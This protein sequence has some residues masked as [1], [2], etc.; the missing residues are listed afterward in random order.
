MLVDKWV[1]STQAEVF[2]RKIPSKYFTSAS[3]VK[4]NG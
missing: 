3:W 2:H 4:K 1:E